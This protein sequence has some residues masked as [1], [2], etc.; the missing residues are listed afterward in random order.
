MCLFQYEG[1]TLNHL[2]DSRIVEALPALEAEES[3]LTTLA[4]MPTTDLKYQSYTMKGTGDTGCS[5]RY[6]SIQPVVMVRK[7]C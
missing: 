4:G 3:G 5:L 1:E 2:S 6:F 7:I